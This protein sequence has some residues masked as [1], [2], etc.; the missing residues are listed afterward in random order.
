MAH[1]IKKKDVRKASDC[2]RNG[3]LSSFR[4]SFAPYISAI[5][6]YYYLF[7]YLSVSDFFSV[8]LSLCL[9]LSLRL[10]VCLSVRLSVHNFF[11]RL[12]L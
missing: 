3:A 4:R 5:Y 10:S 12:L 11:K 8:S 2:V 9:T 7:L 6:Y 1:N